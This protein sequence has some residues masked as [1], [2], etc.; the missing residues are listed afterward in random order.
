MKRILV[1]LV[2]SF[3]FLN[4]ASANG[5]NQAVINDIRSRMVNIFTTI[6]NPQTDE[7]EIFYAN[8]V[9]ITSNLVLIAAHSVKDRDE[10]FI[11][12]QDFL[13][14]IDKERIKFFDQEDFALINI[15]DL[16]LKKVKPIKYGSAQKLN[17]GES[18]IF[19]SRLFYTSEVY[20]D[21]FIKGTICVIGIDL[22]MID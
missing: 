13:I 4:L 15:S 18:V 7:K 22:L 19:A 11:R 2:I 21:F 3:G 1:F 20:F 8:G 14:P 5:F 9:M 10:I 6:I 16:G 12:H 17:Y